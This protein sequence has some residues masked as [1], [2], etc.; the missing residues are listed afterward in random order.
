MDPIL[1]R[2]NVAANKE[3]AIRNYQRQANKIVRVNE[4]EVGD[5]VLLKRTHGS[6]PK[7]NPLWVG[8]FV[9]IKRI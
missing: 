8:P 6:N 7:M 4:Y 9:I 5:E 1:T 2:S 3:E